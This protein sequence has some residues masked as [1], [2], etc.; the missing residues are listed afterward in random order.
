M[1][2]PTSATT[3][4]RP[5]RAADQPVAAQPRRRPVELII[6]TIMVWVWLLIMVGWVLLTFRAPELVP[7]T[8]S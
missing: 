4:I 2:F 1:A 3:P 7:V 6:A 8:L 5:R